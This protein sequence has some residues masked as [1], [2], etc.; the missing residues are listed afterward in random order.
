MVD[1]D[2]LF[3]LKS[4]YYAVLSLFEFLSSS[5]ISNIKSITNYELIIQF[6]IY[7][8]NEISLNVIFGL[9]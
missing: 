3:L 6:H 1:H 9:N 8:Q 5:E 7:T 2:S 4:N